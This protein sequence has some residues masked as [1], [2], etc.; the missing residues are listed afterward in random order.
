MNLQ[1]CSFIELNISIT[2]RPI[3]LL[4]DTGAAISVLKENVLN[5]IV[6]VNDNNIIN[7]TGIG[8]TNTSTIGTV[9]AE[10]YLNNVSCRHTFHV[11]YNN[12][13]IP[14]DGILGLDFIK[15]FDCEINYSENPKLQ[16]KVNNYFINIPISYSPWLS[17]VMTIPPR[18]E[19][20]RKIKYPPI[21]ES[22]LILNQEISPGI[23]IGRSLVSKDRPYVRILNINEE[24][25]E[26]PDNPLQF[27]T[28][29]DYNIITL[30]N[31]KPTRRDELLK[32]LAKKFPKIAQDNLTELCTEYEDIFA[33]PTD[34]VTANN[35]YK[36]KLR[37]KDEVPVYIKNYRIPQTH[38]S[39]INKQVTE[40][41]KNNIIE[42]SI[43]EYN[44]PV[45]LVPKKNLPN[46]KDKRWRMVIDYRKVNEKLLSDKYPLPRIDEILDGLG[47]AKYFSVLDLYSGFHQ[48]ELDENSRDITSFSTDQ[49][50]FRFTRLP[51]GLKIAPNSFQ[52]MISLAFSGLT[53]EKAF[54]YMDD[55]VVFGSS[56][57][58]MTDNLRNV[59]E[60][61][62][63]HCLKLNPEKCEFFKHEV[64]FL[65]HKCTS[66]GIMPD[67][68]KYDKILNYPTPVNS[69]TA[70]R[71]VAFVNYYRRFIKN[72]TEYSW[73]L[74]KLTRKNTPFVWTEN[75][76]KSFDYLKNCLLKPIILKYPDFNKEFCVTTDAS[77][78][79]C[80][81]ILSQEHNGIQMPIAFASRAFTK[82]EQNKP[83]IE[84]ELLAI[85]WALNY[86]KPYLYGKK[87]L[88]RSDHRPLVYLFAM[89]NPSSKLTRVRLDLE[90]FDF[91][92]E[93]IKGSEN[94]GADA[95]SRM[96][97]DN[98]K[99]I[100]R[101]NVVQ[102]RSMK[103]TET[104]QVKDSNKPEL[105]ENKMLKI[106][107]SINLNETKKM[108]QLFFKIKKQKPQCLLKNNSRTLIKF[109]LTSYFVKDKLDIPSILSELEKR[110]DKILV[111][112]VK[113]SLNDELFELIN[114]NQFKEVATKQ[115]N[116]III[117]LTPKLIKICKEEEKK[118]ILEKFHSDPLYGGHIGIKRM[119]AKIKS[120]FTWK[121]MTKDITKHVKNCESC[122]INKSFIKTKEKLTITTTAQTCF[123]LIA[124]DT[125]GPLPKT[126]NNFEYAVTV[127]CELSKYVIAIPI[128]N[129][130]AHTVAK[131][132]VENVFLIYG[133]ARRVLTDCGTEYMN[134][135]M[136]NVLKLL[137]VDHSSS[138]PYHHETLG[139]VERSHRTLNE[140]LRNFVNDKKD[141]WD[142]FL[143]YFTFCYNTTPSTVHGYCPFELVFGKAPN[144]YNFLNEP[145][146]PIYNIELYHKEIANRLK[147]AHKRAQEFIKNSKD[148]NKKTYDKK[149]NQINLKCNDL[150]LID[151]Q[152]RHKLDPL[153]KGPFKVKSIDNTNCTILDEKNKEHTVHK[154]RVKKFSCLFF[155]RFLK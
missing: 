13:S 85:H 108:P 144:L 9:D 38:K 5:S 46:S 135:M 25:K 30:N 33:L 81:A 87:F 67:D 65:G 58:Q 138:T 22:L 150:V 120:K 103:K 141:D 125:I 92:I 137:N 41:L 112:Q 118:K 115:L 139:L 53:P 83:V 14:C 123:D 107:E 19:V 50:S 90:E 64:T 62:R 153:F 149:V 32:L 102:T 60:N 136:K 36:Q 74:T 39:E 47:R 114:I 52:R 34:K 70:K 129:K 71:F 124:I 80:G 55:I 111:R 99:T 15:K 49:G 109:D 40:L 100:S 131:A 134:E 148:N 57:K 104:A 6:R 75:C 121:N 113:L 20:V 61:C 10:I 18:C 44:S 63:K 51:F 126:E 142:I 4:I 3:K 89:K 2:D 127:V 16:V 140:Y 56:K 21:K 28:L 152:N 91:V 151:N 122:Q 116:K 76:Q 68:T 48:I 37:I 35:F 105:K 96:E 119:L 26:I 94:V 93:Y 130:K 132:I 79:A 73:H 97:F 43:S 154:N 84:Q 101:I 1:L 66:N 133:P 27:E 23:F 78:I 69:E 42:P 59:F 106:F 29:V 31:Y 24:E 110:A 147:I 143:K 45:L 7:I 88:V 82:G 72:F 54:I 8:N 17:N 146:D 128:E 155:Y 11:V 86:F 95:L 12:F 77:K 145:I 98:I 117:A